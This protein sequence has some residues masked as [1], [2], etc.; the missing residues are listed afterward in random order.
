MET[1]KILT[2]NGRD[3]I[4][5]RTLA[6]LYADAK[7]IGLQYAKQ[8]ISNARITPA[9]VLSNRNFYYVDDVKQFIPSRTK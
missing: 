3:V 4:D 1:L 2:Y 5:G 7:G 8:R 9:V 6:E